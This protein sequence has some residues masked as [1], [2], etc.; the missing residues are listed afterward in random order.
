MAVPAA[1][2]EGATDQRLSGLMDAA[3][4]QVDELDNEGQAP[5]TP[6]EPPSAPEP[7][8]RAEGEPPSPAAE[9]TPSAEVRK[10]YDDFLA[11]HGGDPE[12]GAQHYFDVMGQNARLAREN[13]DFKNRLKAVEDQQARSA[14]PP[15]VA[16]PPAPV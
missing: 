5:T 8:A 12:K 10:P 11:K 3:G 2:H 16:S 9:A 14:Q 4:A 13:E 7:P 15:P 1:P 6:A